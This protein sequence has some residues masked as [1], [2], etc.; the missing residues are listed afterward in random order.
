MPARLRFFSRALDD[1]FQ[2]TICMPLLP[3]A[4]KEIFVNVGSDNKDIPIGSALQFCICTLS[5]MGFESPS[6][7]KPKKE[8]FVIFTSSIGAAALW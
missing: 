1:K 7:Y 5:M 8:L 3:L 6:K 2:S 4:S